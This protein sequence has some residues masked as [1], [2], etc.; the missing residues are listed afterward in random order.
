MEEYEHAILEADNYVSNHLYIHQNGKVNKLEQHLNM[1][2]KLGNIMMASDDASYQY[3]IDWFN[4]Q[5]KTRYTS[6]GVRARVED[7]AIYF[8]NIYVKK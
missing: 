2:P 5:L 8:D 4:N 6:I 3:D 1:F 7:T